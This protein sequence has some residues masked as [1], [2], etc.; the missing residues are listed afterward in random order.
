MSPPY[1]Q[2]PPP[3]PKKQVKDH[4][5]D[6]GNAG[7]NKRLVYSPHQYGPSVTGD[8]HFAGGTYM[9][10]PRESCLGFV[11]VFCLGFGV[12]GG[13]GGSFC[14]WVV[15]VGGWDMIGLNGSSLNLG[16]D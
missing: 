3:P 7:F 12:L 16:F 1:T 13:W 14:G 11:Y 9:G 5:I 10:F 6:F 2:P 4:P 8:A 15:W